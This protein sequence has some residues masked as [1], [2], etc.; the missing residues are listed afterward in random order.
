MPCAGVTLHLLTTKYELEASSGKN[1]L[2]NALVEL[3]NDYMHG[4][5]H[6]KEIWDIVTI[7]YLINPDWISTSLIQARSQPTS[8]WV[9][10]AEGILSVR[11]GRLIAIFDDLFKSLP[12]KNKSIKGFTAL[13]F[14]GYNNISQCMTRSFYMASVLASDHHLFLYRFCR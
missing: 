9:W 5:G 11:R 1:K 2:C 14:M 4:S 7:A 6:A 8:T 12:I 10:I 13:Y 3:F